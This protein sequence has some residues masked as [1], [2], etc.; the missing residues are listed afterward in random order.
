MRSQI[1]SNAPSRITVRFAA[2]FVRKPKLQLQ[3]SCNAA[4]R[5]DRRGIPR[6]TTGITG[7]VGFFFLFF[8]LVVSFCLPFFFFFLA[9]YCQNI[10]GMASNDGRVE[11]RDCKVSW[12]R[13]IQ[14]TSIP[15]PHSA[16][17]P[18]SN[19]VERALCRCRR[20]R[21][22]RSL[23]YLLDLWLAKP[24][25]RLLRLL[26]LLPAARLASPRLLPRPSCSMQLRFFWGAFGSG[27]LAETWL[28][29]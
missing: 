26:L 4:Q 27:W 25:P 14:P 29:D 22:S 10:V 15:W 6:N 2:R 19:R 8:S 13:L 23:H 1:S 3:R 20:K 7:F 11:A 21:P 24:L 16:L 12:S 9:L 18:S 5:K 17:V 28:S